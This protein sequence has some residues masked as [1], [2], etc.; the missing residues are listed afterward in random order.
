[1]PP[2]SR[3]TILLVD[4]IPANIMVLDEIL[5]AD[6]KLR[7]ATS[8]EQALKIAQ[9]P[10]PP[11]LI[12]LDV[13]MPGIDGFEVCRRLKAHSLTRKIP[14]IFVTAMDEVKDEALGFELGAVDYI[15]KPVTPALVKARVRTHL[16]LY[17]QNR[18]LD[19]LVRERTRE[20]NETRLQVIRR[21]GRAGEFRDNETGLHVL[22]VGHYCRLIAEAIGMDE[23]DVDLIYSAAPM[24]DIGKIGI[25]DNLLL[26]PGKLD[27]DEFEEI[28]RHA[29]IGAEILGEIATGLLGTARVI[30]LTHHEKWNGSGYPYGLSGDDIPLVGRITAIADVFDALTSERPYKHAWPVEDAVAFI[31]NQAGEQFDP[32]LVK[33]FLDILPKIV[34]CRTLYDDSHL[35]GEFDM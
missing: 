8:G 9:S 22:R 4:D 34:E 10:G 12:L 17:D 16:A 19:R 11:D 5:S 18:E 29:V 30:A 21:L 13:L 28:K 1:V 33:T 23:E 3:Q 24:H 6:Y 2:I 35:P 31:E 7:A 15:H 20:L 32:V 14:V 27:P 26:K 25:R